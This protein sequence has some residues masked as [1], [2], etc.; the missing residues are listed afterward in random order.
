MRS[1][2]SRHDNQSVSLH[3][4]PYRLSVLIPVGIVL[5]FSYLVGSNMLSTQWPLSLL[6]LLATQHTHAVDVSWHPPKNT[7]INDLDKVLSSSGVYGFIFNSSRTP[8]RDYGQ[9][10][11]CNMPHVR[12]RE[13]KKPPKGYELQYVEVVCRILHGP[14]LYELN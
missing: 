11:W 6:V 13:Y 4:S 9:Y 5:F 7:E 8:N 3:Q 14:T 1:L 10:N 12:R 2:E